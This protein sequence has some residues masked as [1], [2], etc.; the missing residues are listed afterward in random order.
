MSLPPTCPPSYNHGVGATPS[1]LGPCSPGPAHSA[2]PLCDPTG[3]PHL[4]GAGPFLKE[5]HTPTQGSPLSAFSPSCSRH[6]SWGLVTNMLDG[7]PASQGRG[8]LAAVR[9]SARPRGRAS[10]AD[11]NP[12]HWVSGSTLHCLRV[13]FSR[14]TPSFQWLCRPLCL[15][16]LL[17]PYK[18]VLDSDFS[19]CYMRI[20]ISPD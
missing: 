5:S 6:P 18:A 19:I 16:I 11:R 17:T 15:N 10:S 9:E 20:P 13:P 2:S 8:R 1:L 14:T 3:S 12:G 4:L 7:L